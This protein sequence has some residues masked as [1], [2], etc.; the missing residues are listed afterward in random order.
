MRT[1]NRI[2][3]TE[4]DAGRLRAILG[5]R[6]V[7]ALDREHFLDL[8]DELEQ[9][10]VVPE[11]EIPKDVVTLQSQVC[12]RDRKTGVSS[13]YTIVSPDQANVSLGHI[14]VV[15]PLGTALLGYREGD[16][17]EWQMP[18]GVRRLQIERV[19]QPRSR[20]SSP[21]ARRSASRY[22]TSGRLAHS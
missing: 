12:V 15:A 2:I 6:G 7:S 22:R 5:S 18:G 11:E 16:Q 8:Y 19:R 4:P 3:V 14:S 1:S 21:P 9:A 20:S 13:D 17:V 10:R